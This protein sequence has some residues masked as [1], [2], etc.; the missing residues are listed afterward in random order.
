MKNFDVSNHI[1]IAGC[2]HLG[3]KVVDSL[4]SRRGITAKNISTLVKTEQSRD[5]CV[6]KGCESFAINLD[7]QDSVVPSLFKTADTLLYYF[8]PPPRQGRE[9]S[10]AREFI[11]QLTKGR[12]FQPK[13]IVL[14]ST[15]GVYGN[16]HG[17]WVDE[18]SPVNPQ[19]DRALRRVDAEQQFQSYSHTFK[20]PL[21]ILRVSGIYGA[22]K[23][24]LRRIRAKI[25]IVRKEDSPYSN[26]IHIDDLFEICIEAGFSE[27]ISG[28]YNCADGH[29]TTMYDYFIKV[30]QANH[31]PEPQVISLE[32]ARKQL[33]A[34]MLSYMDESRR[35]DNKKLLKYFN[36]RLK[37]P[38]LTL[39]NLREKLC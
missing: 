38:E 26:R 21:V 5:L 15:T 2:G 20:I 3:R 11:S 4:L 27:H 24:P 33:S 22:G 39:E 12:S 14:I 35:I 9:D 23:L 8:I 18:M 34:G 1:V 29:P 28:I 32:Q 16:C 10:R 31:L 25:P 17:K 30:A 6:E 7:K 19:V 36:L 37:H 13:K